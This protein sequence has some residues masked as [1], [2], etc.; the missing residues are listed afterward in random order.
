M[1]RHILR[2]MFQSEPFRGL[3]FLVSNLRCPGWHGAWRHSVLAFGTH[4]PGVREPSRPRSCSLPCS[5]CPA[6]SCVSPSISKPASGKPSRTDPWSS[7]FCLTHPRSS[8]PVFPSYHPEPKKLFIAVSFTMNKMWKT[9]KCLSAD[10]WR[11]KTWSVHTAEHYLARSRNAGLTHATTW[12]NFENTLSERSQTQKVRCRM[13]PLTGVSRED[14]FIETESRWEVDPSRGLGGRRVGRGSW[15]V[16]GS[17]CV[18]L[19]WL[20]RHRLSCVLSPW[21]CS[22][23]LPARAIT[24]QREAGVT[25]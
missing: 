21:L 7:S 5:R 6:A 2:Y 16:R 15:W 8:S 9:A 13:N 4:R 17:F 11:D 3:S 18:V 12:V 25:K 10:D 22:L 19:W 24:A 20:G 23:Y 1:P 14:R